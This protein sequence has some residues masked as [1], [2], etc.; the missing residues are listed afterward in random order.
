MR[1]V[2]RKRLLILVILVVIVVAVILTICLCKTNKESALKCKSLTNDMSIKFKG[3][4][5]I[6]VSGKI[7]LDGVEEIEKIEEN[8]SIY[9]N[10]LIL[11]K[12][13]KMIRYAFS[14]NEINSSALNFIGLSYDKKMT[15]DKIKD[16]LQN[17]NYYCK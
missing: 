8:I 15:Y 6:Y 2:K 1:K 7:N 5:P 17:N 16:S 13:K 12:S 11:D 9:N 3:N 4:K 10:V 14:Y